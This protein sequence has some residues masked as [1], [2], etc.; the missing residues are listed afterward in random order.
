M[1]GLTG[2]ELLNGAIIKESMDWHDCALHVS[3]QGVRITALPVLISLAT[4]PGF[5]S[6]FKLP[7]CFV[8]S[9][10]GIYDRVII[11]YL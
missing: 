4:N 7:V 2:H 5:V 3:L 8:C 10:V 1:T 6:P 11:C 9:P